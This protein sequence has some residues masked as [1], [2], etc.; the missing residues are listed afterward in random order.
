LAFIRGQILCCLFA[1]C[2]GG[3]I[4][5]FWGEIGGI[6]GFLKKIQKN[7]SFFG[8]TLIFF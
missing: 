1:C 5:D 6:W 4:G 7:E 2:D 8:K 3:E